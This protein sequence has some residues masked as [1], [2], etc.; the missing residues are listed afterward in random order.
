MNKKQWSI[1]RLSKYIV[2]VQRY[3]DPVCTEKAEMLLQAYFQYLRNRNT[4]GKDRK[5]IR[6]LESLIRLSEAHAR[7]MHKNDID[8]Y[9]AICV[10]ILME[11]CMSTGLYDEVPPVIMS[12]QIYEKA[13]Y[14]TLTKL[15]LTDFSYFEDDFDSRLSSDTNAREQRP[16]NMGDDTA[17]MFET[18]FFNNDKTDFTAG[19]SKRHTQR[20]Q[21]GES[22]SRIADDTAAI[23][24]DS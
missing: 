7:L 2:Y 21:R 20:T 18:T 1:E 19:T 15:G 11:H 12:K 13:K 6:M 9:D 10:I 17:F 3:I 5:T 14:E 16:N 24:V 22:A 4:L 8:I 23:L